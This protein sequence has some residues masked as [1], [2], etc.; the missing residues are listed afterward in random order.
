MT[1]EAGWK[2]MIEERYGK[3]GD[4]VLPEVDPSC[5]P[6]GS[7]PLEP[8][9]V[10]QAAT[11]RQLDDYREFDAGAPARC[12]QCGTGTGVVKHVGEGG[13]VWGCLPCGHPEDS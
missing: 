2:A 8:P 6:P 11:V 12:Y 7:Q 10:A 4:G 5:Y 9:M 3:P 1:T 13:F